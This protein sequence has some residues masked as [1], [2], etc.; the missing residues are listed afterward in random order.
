MTANEFIK[1]RKKL[2]KKIDALEDEISRAYDAVT[3]PEMSQ[4]RKATAADVIKG[5]AFFY[6]V[7]EDEPWWAIIA[8]VRCPKDPFKAYVSEDGCNHGIEGAFVL[9]EKS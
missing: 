1:L 4:L 5:N 2:Q 9:K 7:G 8:D 3:I 6:R